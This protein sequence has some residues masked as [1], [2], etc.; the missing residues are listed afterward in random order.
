MDQQNPY[1]AFQSVGDVISIDPTLGLNERGS[2]STGSCTAACT[3]LSTSAATAGQC[4]SCNNTT[5]K[6]VKA[7]WS[8]YT[9]ICSG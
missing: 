3:K 7:S 6:F 4:C 5:R 8:A 1:V 2:T 9:F